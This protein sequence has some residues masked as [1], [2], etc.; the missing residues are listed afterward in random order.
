MTTQ[1]RM[2]EGHIEKLTEWKTKQGRTH[3]PNNIMGLKVEPQSIQKDFP[4]TSRP[5]GQ[6]LIF[7]C[8]VE[9]R[10]RFRFNVIMLV[11]VIYLKTFL[12]KQSKGYATL[13][14]RINTGATSRVATGVWHFKDDKTTAGSAVIHLKHS[15]NINRGVLKMSRISFNNLSLLRVQIRAGAV[16]Y[17][18]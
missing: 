9:K 6:I 10:K 2:Y 14:N 13:H 4:R 15:L 18:K 17:A 16:A 11:W 1:S 8:E 7:F 12:V 3:P 5:S